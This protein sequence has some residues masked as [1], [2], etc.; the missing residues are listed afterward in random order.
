MVTSVLPLVA[1][2]AAIPERMVTLTLDPFWSAILFV[3]ALVLTC[4]ALSLLKGLELRSRRI[5]RRTARTLAFPRA[6]V[7]TVGHRSA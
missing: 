1:S 6:A 3:T 5:A 2:S 4:G 7:A